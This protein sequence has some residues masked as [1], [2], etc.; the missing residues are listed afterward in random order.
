M[1]QKLTEEQE[2]AVLLM[3]AEY[4]EENEGEHP[5]PQQMNGFIRKVTN[6]ES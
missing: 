3:V 5:S 6:E 2:A 4:K 1:A